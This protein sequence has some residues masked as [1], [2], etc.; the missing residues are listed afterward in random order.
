MVS[1]KDITSMH[2]DTKTEWKMKTDT[3]G[4][5]HLEAEDF[6]VIKYNPKNLSSYQTVK[7]H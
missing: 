7:Q 1:K 2:E 3:V 6:S 4:N 5:M